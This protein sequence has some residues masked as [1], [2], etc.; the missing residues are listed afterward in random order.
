M[1]GLAQ[2]GASLVHRSGGGGE[3]WVSGAIGSWP[4]AIDAVLD[5]EGGLDSVQV[6]YGAV[7]AAMPISDGPVDFDLRRVSA[8]A[9][10]V[11]ELLEQG[12]HVLVHCG[13]GIN[14]ANLVAGTA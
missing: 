10:L 14:R 8:L 4:D 5:L 9:R 13:A 3:L 1:S 6:P 12:A 7:Y 11:A 2:I